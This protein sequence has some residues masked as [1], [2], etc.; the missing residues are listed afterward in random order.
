MAGVAVLAAIW[1]FAEVDLIPRPTQFNPKR[2]RNFTVAALIFA[3]LT[4]APGPSLGS[5]ANAP[6][7]LSTST[8][9]TL[10]AGLLKAV[11][12][13]LGPQA[14]AALASPTL[15]PQDIKLIPPGPDPQFCSTGLPP[16]DPLC[17]P[18]RTTIGEAINDAFLAGVD[19]TVFVQAGAYAEE[20]TIL[21]FT[22]DLTLLGIAGSGSTIIGVSISIDQNVA[23]V[24]VAGFSILNTTN[25]IGV[26]AFNNT[27]TIALSDL[28]VRTDGSD[29]I[30]VTGDGG[31]IGDVLLNAVNA[32]DTGGNGANILAQ[33]QVAVDTSTFNGNADAG[34]LID[35]TATIALTD[36]IASANDAG[37]VGICGFDPASGECLG[38]G[39]LT[40]SGRFNDNY[41]SGLSLATGGRVTLENLTANG[42][43]QAANDPTCDPA[44]QFCGGSGVNIEEAQG[45]VVVHN[46][47]FNGNAD[48]G[49]GINTPDKIKLEHVTASG[50][51][52]NGVD[53]CNFDPNTDSCLGAGAVTISGTFNDNFHNGLGIASSAGVRLEDVMANNNGQSRSDPDCNPEV[54]FCGGGGAF[55]EA[56]GQVEVD[57][58]T[59]NE[60]GEGGL[61]IN[62]PGKIKLKDVRASENGNN[63]I[64]MC[65]FDPDTDRCLGARDVRLKDV[66]ANNN[67]QSRTDPACVPDAQ[68]CGGG[69]TFIE[70]QSRVVVDSST[71]NGNADAGLGINT[72]DKIKLEHVTAS[73]NGQNGVD[74]CNFDPNTDS[75]LGAGA[76]TIS[77]TFNDNFHNGL[78]IASSAGVR[79][80]DVMA[81][82]NGQSRSDPDCNPEVQFCGGGGAFIEAQ[83][84]VEVD[85]STFNENGE[86][87]LSINTPGK[88][89]LKDVRASENGNNGIDMC[90][91]DPDT[92]RCLGAGDVTLENVTASN[93]GQSRTDPTCNPDFQFCGGEGAFIEAQGRVVVDSGMFNDNADGGLVIDTPAKITLS[94]VTASGNGGGGGV[95]ICNFDPDADR[96]LGA[97]AVTISGTFSDNFHHGLEIVSTTGVRLEEV[98]ASNNGQSRTDPT[99]NPEVQFC[100]GNGAF[101]EAQGRVTVDPSTFNGNADTGLGIDTP[102][103]IKLE[104]VSASGNGQNGVNICNFDPD[105]DRCLGAGDVTLEHVMANNNGQSRTDPDCNPEV[106]FCGGN[107]LEINTPAVI[108]LT[109]VTASGNGGEGVFICNFDPGTESCLGSNGVRVNGIF[110]ENYLSGLAIFSNAGVALDNV[111]AN[112]N[113]QSVS[114]PLCDLEVRDCGG[115]GAFLHAQGPVL[116][117][118][119]AFDGNG[120]VG[121]GLNTPHTITLTNVSASDNGGAG[122]ENCNFDELSESCL[123]SGAVTVNGTANHFDNNYTSG[124]FLLSNASMTLEN[125]TANNNGQSR[126]DPDCNPEVQFCGGNG[127]FIEAQGRVVVDPSTFNGNAD[128]GLQ[129]NTLGKIKLSEVS[130][131]SNGELGAFLFTNEHFYEAVTV[132]GGIDWFV[133]RDAAELRTL[134]GVQGHLV[135]ITSALEDNFIAMNFP[136]AFPVIPSPRPPGCEGPTT[137]E[138]TCGFPYWFGGFQPPGSPNEPEGDWEWVTGEP[139]VYTNWHDGEPND[140][141][142]REEDCLHPHPDGS[143][144]NDSQ[145]DDRRAGGYV[146]EYDVA[147]FASPGGGNIEVSCSIFQ[148]NGFL[149]VSA[150]AGEGTM[151]LNSVTGGDNNVDGRPESDIPGPFVGDFPDFILLEPGTLVINTIECEPIE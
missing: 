146:V 83:G 145:C 40:V 37:G 48:A 137:V 99:C 98:T 43:G 4:L 6:R 115:F 103:K 26:A 69:G 22:H 46:S 114:D 15:T 149:G 91:F 135:T 80:E 118:H 64:D 96:C 61:S 127:A 86:G 106:Q 35:G 119:S 19:G 112:N 68:F 97:G 143:L 38:S 77:G 128:T 10:P 50:N 66:T 129:I 108:T 111:A 31:H 120:E 139:F 49:L 36:V 93:N 107:G 2:P 79:L 141:Q 9:A 85:S 148:L 51:G 124:L 24:S 17:S 72:P 39:P 33:G 1:I 23:N 3:A 105:T 32:S 60:N 75:C 117:D 12:G 5:A 134:S 125:V 123:G 136:E 76:V 11:R 92:H 28:V 84:Q 132:S 150:D 104:G 87:G 59:F 30:L 130:A 121:L 25:N 67:G 42:N 8:D 95:V 71:F 20:V 62:T 27:G 126:S 140:F 90:N 47:T 89:K 16:G 122:V 70:A 82:N 74:I 56:Q 101:I 81:N 131:S 52:Q 65:N 44:S 133:A 57:S 7:D 144:W 142:G 94:E 45:A 78:G 34:L 102:G 151:T 58:S 100:G 63:G 53:I 14:A 54:Q 29:G 41:H 113:G 18:E 138:N 116:V 147:P 73:G 88:I 109:D 13:A 110:N 21:G 55:I